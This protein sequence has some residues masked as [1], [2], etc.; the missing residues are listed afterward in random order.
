MEKSVDNNANQRHETKE[1]I[2]EGPPS[3][4][5]Q[6]T[7]RFGI[8]VHVQPAE[9]HAPGQKR[10][11]DKKHQNSDAVEKSFHS[12]GSPGQK[13]IDNDVVV[14]NGHELSKLYEVE[15]IVRCATLSASAAL[16]RKESRWGASHRRIDY[17]EKDDVNW[18]RHITLHNEKE[19][20]TINVGTMPITRMNKGG[21]TS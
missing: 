10:G 18:M 9:D 7:R 20:G 4:N 13:E 15:H 16:E 1:G 11:D 12:P 19:S 3:R 8:V 5:R 17:P 2:G 6:D 14:S 21:S